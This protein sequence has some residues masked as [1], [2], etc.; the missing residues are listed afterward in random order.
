V[1]VVATG[2]IT[3]NNV[4]SNNAVITV[5]VDASGNITGNN[6]TSNNAVT[7]V[8]VSAS[9][10]I[11]GN[12]LVSNNDVTTVSV[13]ASGNV[14]GVTFLG[15]VEGTYANFTGNVTA[16]NFIGNIQGNID[17]GGANTEIQ[18]NDNDLLAGSPGF[19]FD[20]T[21]NLVSVSGNVSAANVI[22]S[23]VVS[24]T[25]NVSG[26]NITTG[27]VVTATGN[28]SGGNLTTTGQVS[29]T[30]NVAGGNVVSSN[31]VTTITVTASGNV[32][33][34][35]LI[36]NNAVVTA[37]VSATGNITGNNLV[38]N[39][40]VTTATVTAT[41][42]V[43]GGNITTIGVVAATGNVSGGN[44]TTTGRVDATGNIT[45]GNVNT[46]G[47]VVATGNVA[48]GNVVSGNDVTTITVTASGNVTGNNL[49][50]N[51]DV[52]T[53]TVTATGNV[54]GGNI[55]TIGM[56]TAT[57][58]VSGGNITTSGEVV[59]TGNV[60]GNN[61]SATA[62]IAGGNIAV[63]GVSDLG[64]IR[65]AGND[66][67][68][69][70]SNEITINSAGSDI[71]LR[72]SG[73]S[74]ANLLV[75][76]AGSD[77]VLIGTATPTTNAALKIGTT[78]SILL[79]VGN[80]VQR[81]ATGVTGMLRFNTTEDTIEYYDSDSWNTVT[82]DFTVIVADDFNGDG[83]TVNF[84]L[85]QDSTTAATIVSINGVVQIPVTAYSVTGNVLTFTE[86]PEATDVIDARILTTTTTV[87]ELVDAGV[88]VVLDPGAGDI[89]I[90]GNLIPTANV[91]Y[92]LGNSTN[93]WNNLYLA[94]NTIY[95]G[96]LQLKEVNSTTFGV[97][98]ADGNTQ[99]DIDVGNIDVSAIGS[100]TST[101]GIVAPN[102][103]VYVTVG[104]AAN[105]LVVSSTTVAI[106]GDATVSGNVTAQDVNS[107]SDATLKTNINAL[108][109]VDAVIG[110]LRGVEYDWR[111]GSGH[112]Y[113]FLAQEV[114]QILP[115]AVKTGAD[116][117]KSINYMMIIPFLVETIK[118][119]GAEVADL[120]KRLD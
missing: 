43:A 73:D 105:V 104:G 32:T 92:D 77:S 13:T 22:S 65:I 117:L 55:T 88:S 115:A 81:P 35:N 24:A 34:N 47:Q 76:D 38:S 53:A 57:G 75:V 3:G 82:G 16:A 21:S 40:D 100:G 106:T 9:G 110:Q 78:N 33:G 72:V 6:V 8:S 67:T 97:F 31:D 48:G 19:T 89:L 111:N 83:S 10:N 98:T 107:L 102:G 44:L 79:P 46:T 27:G 50:A 37:T 118:Q 4:T 14:S 120:K 108:T 114:E 60:S 95:L 69:S 7:T 45:G 96:N 70:A 52:T 26:G 56:V 41:G 54:S 2:N 103:N 68:N 36:S 61:I 18:F 58:N 109:G 39:N 42:N 119:L 80:T 94:G 23:G 15:N 5:S 112:S 25:G 87:T 101:I 66:I 74:E 90:T 11:A 93:F 86:A 64:N 12:N 20:K 71:N 51:N 28:V 59:A 84:T 116:G 62:N 63:T 29:A 99:A 49:I 113:G 1:S 30:G 17:A 85:S 91:T